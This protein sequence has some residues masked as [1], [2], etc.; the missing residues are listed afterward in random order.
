[1]NT[2]FFSIVLPTYNRA[3]ILPK[4]IASV[5]KQTYVNWE[6]LVVDDGSTDNTKKIV[7][8][9]NDNRVSYLSQDN[10]ERSVARNNGIK[11]ATGQYVCFLDSDDLFEPHHL[12]V[13]STEILARNNPKELIFTNCFYLNHG[14]KEQP[15][16]P[17]LKDNT[18]IYLLEHSIVPA[19]VCVH[20]NILKEFQF[21]ED[22]VIVEDTVLWIMIAN[23]YP[24]THITNYTI[25]YRLHD[26]NSVNIKNNCFLPRLRGLEKLFQDKEVSNKIG[27]K[28]KNEIISN[29]YLGIAKHY[30]YKRSFIKMIVNLVKSFFTN[31][32]SNL[33]KFK[34]YMIYRYLINKEDV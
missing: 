21:R 26:D 8:D 13:L 19:R 33:N 12:Q 10:Q 16:F 9:I 31:P 5:L 15:A 27:K 2:P 23:K 24:V 25:Q 29:C 32:S 11:N 3:Q 30:E 22:I 6:L 28:I 17:V 4:T 1:M 14:K 7:E 20:K 18:L 34:I